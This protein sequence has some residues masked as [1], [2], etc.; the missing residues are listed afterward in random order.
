MHF[1][2]RKLSDTQA[3]WLLQTT[4]PPMPELVLIFKNPF[5]PHTRMSFVKDP[6]S[7]FLFLYFT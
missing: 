6:L 7:I 2:W 3:P 4:P 5:S 1:T